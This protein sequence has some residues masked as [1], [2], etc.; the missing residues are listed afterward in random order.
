MRSFGTDDA[1][2][3]HEETKSRARAKHVFTQGP[4]NTVGSGTVLEDGDSSDDEAHDTAD[5]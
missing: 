2:N 5:G 4:H 1:A 3:G